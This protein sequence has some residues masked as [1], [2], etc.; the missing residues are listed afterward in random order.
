[1]SLCEGCHAGC[2]RSFAVPVSGADVL[3]IVRHQGLSFWEFVCR[4][5][6][7]DGSIAGN[8]APH[9]YFDDEPDTPFV[10]CLTHV[11]SD[12]F[13][14]TTRCRFLLEAP[15]NNGNGD[16]VQ[17]VGAACG[18]YADRP[19][20]CRVFPA[21]MM[22]RNELAILYDV[23]EYGRPG[24]EPAYRLCPRQWTPADVDPIEQVQ[25]LVVAQYEMNFYT[26]LVQSWNRDPGPWL[27]FPDFLTQ[28]YD[29]R[30]QPNPDASQAALRLW[31]PAA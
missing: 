1:M 8:Y 26:T 15:D 22:P 2:C 11:P 24:K 25:D 21:K 29:Q 19:V 18:I 10:L 9:V 30:V 3:Q 31:N 17:S 28:V 7:P 5:A 6:D 13:P 16:G 4:W 20:A 27:A 23:P 14:G 12:Q